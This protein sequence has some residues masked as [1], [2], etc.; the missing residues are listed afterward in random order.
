MPL[1]ESLGSASARGTGMF[2]QVAYA[3]ALPNTISNLA[4]WYTADSWTGSSWTDLSGNGRNATNYYGNIAKN[5]TYSAQNGANKT[6]T[7][8]SSLGADGGIRLPDVLDA[9][10][11][12]TFFNVTRRIGATT[13]SNTEL[14]GR[15]WDG[16]GDNWL[17]GFH[18]GSS[19]VAYHMNWI[20]PESAAGYDTYVNNWT[21]N[22]DQ[23][24]LFRTNGVRYGP[25]NTAGAVATSTTVT[26]HYGNY[27]GPGG[28]GSEKGS[29]AVAEAIWFNR[30]LSATEYKLVEGYL[31]NKYGMTIVQ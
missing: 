25:N 18:G 1:L 2:G 10:A 13:G 11:N 26:L 5:T 4:A 23:L 16:L 12:Y 21:I 7:V 3:Q 22:T 6:F 19:G 8:I 9:N 20:T 15:I 17:S 27:A 29:W 28:T 30:E 14:R 31:A 24:N